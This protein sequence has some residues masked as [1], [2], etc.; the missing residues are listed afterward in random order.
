MIIQ[1]S[2]SGQVRFV[3]R[4]VDHARLSGRLAEAFGNDTFAPLEPREQMVF[5]TAHHDEGWAELD[6]AAP[7]DPHTDLPYQFTETPRALVAPVH[8]RSPEFNERHHPFCGLLASMHTWGLYHGRYGLAERATIDS[9]SPADKPAVLAML[10]AELGRQA[11]LQG[12]LAADAATQG[13]ADDSMLFNCYQQLQFFDTLSLYFCLGD[14]AAPKPAVFR[15]VPLAVGADVTIDV[16]PLRAGFYGLSP[17]PF[18]KDFLEVSLTGR[19]M[20]PVPAPADLARNLAEAPE[21]TQ[22][23]T[24]VD[25]SSRA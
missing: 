8:A 12:E 17:Y 25:N 13:W 5:V 21:H 10:Q 4:Q 6:A 16:R 11:R 1:S 23:F 18:A 22:K 24:L 15:R 19:F 7:R 9:V 14:P 2:H 20:L 3:I